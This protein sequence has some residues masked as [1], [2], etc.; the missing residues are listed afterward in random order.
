MTKEIGWDEAT[1]SGAFVKLEVDEEKRIVITNW[2]FEQRDDKAQ[3]AAGKIE[4]IADVLE[5]DGEPVNSKL[6][7]TTSNRLKAKLRP[8]LE[9]K[10][11]TDKVKIS[12]LQVGESF[13]TQYSVKMVTD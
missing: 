9:G 10:P 1:K 7:T 8:V 5:E 3:V 13:N 2:R 12:I 4:L 11:V 6:F